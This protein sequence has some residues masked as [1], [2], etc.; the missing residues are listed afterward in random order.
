MSLRKVINKLYAL[1]IVSYKGFMVGG[2]VKNINTKCM[3]FGSVGEVVKIEE[4]PNN[5]GY[6]VHYKV[7]NSGMNFNVGDVLAK[8]ED[9]LDIYGG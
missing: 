2:L 3:H 5:A 6:L 1:A 9:Q 4:L 8:T 7:T